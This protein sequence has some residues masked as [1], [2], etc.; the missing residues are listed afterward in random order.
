MTFL[1]AMRAITNGS[2][3]R[4][5]SWDKDTYMFSLEGE[6]MQGGESEVVPVDNFHRNEI[7]YADWEI[8]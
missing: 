5:N 8:Y 1:E 2:S 6:L 3:V 7:I 4:H